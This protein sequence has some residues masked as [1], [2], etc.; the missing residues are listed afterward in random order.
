MTVEIEHDMD[1]KEMLKENL[2]L[3]KEI[4]SMTKKMKRHITFQ[5]MVSI[6]YFLL[7]IVPII[8]S[9]IYLPPLLKN[10]LGPYQELLGGSS[11]GIMDLFKGGT[12]D[13]NLNDLKNINTNATNTQNIDIKKLPPDVQKLL[14]QKK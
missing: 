6:F 2:K 1:V 3:T 9:I 4:H 14:Q 11:G 12:G 7:I 5:K 10:M 8:L 13:F